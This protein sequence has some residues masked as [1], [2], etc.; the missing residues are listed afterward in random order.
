MTGQTIAFWI[1]ALT[2]AV[3]ALAVVLSRNVFRA[4]LSLVVC[5]LA[6]AG[7][8]VVLYADFLAAIQVLIYVGAI[9]V[10]IIMSI[11]LTREVERGNTAGRLALPALI[12]STAFIAIAIWALLNTDWPVTPTPPLETTTNALGNILF[13]Q[14]GIVLILEV[15]ALLIVATIVGAISI[16]REK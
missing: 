14:D 4:A 11:M 12:S 5:F 13:N 1:L 6:V 3:S 2:G 15:S 10:L 9:A 16:V 7:L 8:F